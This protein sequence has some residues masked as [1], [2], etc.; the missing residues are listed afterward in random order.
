MGHVGRFDPETGSRA[1]GFVCPGEREPPH[2]IQEIGMKIRSKTAALAAALL[3][4]GVAGASA[5]VMVEPEGEPPMIAPGEPTDAQEPGDLVEQR[6]AG[7]PGAFG[8]GA[9]GGGVIEAEPQVGPVP[10]VPPEEEMGDIE[11]ED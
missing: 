4:A 5:Q 3:L 8:S 6:R 2:L 10:A 9:A 7:S 1:P 11:D